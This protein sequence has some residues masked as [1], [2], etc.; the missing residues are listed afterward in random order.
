MIDTELK[1][2]STR[3]LL[4]LPAFEYPG[5]KWKR[6]YLPDNKEEM[7]QLFLTKELEPFRKFIH[8]A[9]IYAKHYFQ[10]IDGQNCPGCHRPTDYKHVLCSVVNAWPK[11]PP[12]FSKWFNP[13]QK[14]SYMVTYKRLFEPYVIGSTADMALYKPFKNPKQTVSYLYCL[15]L[16]KDLLT[17]G[18][19]KFNSII[20][21]IWWDSS[22]ESCPS[23]FM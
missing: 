23:L 19:I 2:T 3:T 1:L 21:S 11:R 22:F 13:N 8:F 14:T 5:K 6:V 20:S 17:T 16:T 18:R 7:Y 12:A 10:Y 15:D 9:Q 4:V